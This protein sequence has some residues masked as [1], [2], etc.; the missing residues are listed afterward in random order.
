MRMNGTEAVAR[1][2]AADRPI[3]R[4]TFARSDSWI[5]PASLVAIASLGAVL[6]VMPD[7]LIPDASLGWV[8]AWYYVGFASNPR[9]DLR[10][11]SHLLYQAERLSWTLPGYLANLVA[12]PLVANYLTKSVFHVA[13]VCFLFG[14]L[15]LSSGLRTAAFVSCAAALY[16]FVLHALGANLVDGAA[17]TYFVIATYLVNRSMTG[18]R[19]PLL[20]AFLSG[21]AYFAAIIAHLALVV[22]L[23]FFAAYVAL[24]RAQ[25]RQRSDRSIVTLAAMFAAGGT[26][27]YLCLV[28]LYRY[29]GIQT[30]P[31]SLSFDFFATH[32]PN[33]LIWPDSMEWLP[34]ALWLWLPSAVM[35]SIA[36]AAAN[37]VLRDGPR[38]LA[39]IPAAQWLF[40]ALA[41]AWIAAAV[42]ARAPLMMLPFYV[43]YLIPVAFLAVG[44]LLDSHIERLSSR[45]YWCLISLT[46]LAPLVAYRISDSRFTATAAL[47]AAALS[48][49][50]VATGL[51][52]T[53]STRW[54]TPAILAL[55][56]VALAAIDY[57]TAD[58]DVQ[59]WNAYRHTSMADIY[60]EPR[61]T[62]RWNATRAE[63]YS[64]VVA[65]AARLA[66][67]LAGKYYQFWYDG[68]D[69]MGMYF[70]SIG[71]MFFAWSTDRI[72]NE[73]FPTLTATSI[74][75]VTLKPGEPLR[76]IVVLTRDAAVSVSGLPVAVR[77]RW[78]ER[79]VVAGTQY[80]A[81]YF[82]IIY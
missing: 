81:H 76:D 62:A 64:G 1:T 22:I 16:S 15:R 52:V 65:T 43:S 63:E 3:E 39:R 61:A 18:R 49:A 45:M 6:T 82:A 48:L 34:S 4:E 71:S 19:L 77:P 5:L 32:G 46:F 23:P 35:V 37:A 50:A 47:V 27:V 67:R 73:R 38:S 60:H 41:G 51:L 58:F 74:E 55:V 75:R 79:F 13:T 30:R 17:T 54:R 10:E 56:V 7:I 66:P 9:D 20:A 72:L 57:A 29:W 25:A 59:L 24:F 12:P 80:F 11:F 28:W 8:D 53:A 14:A 26:A 69:P 40:A 36:L 70:R 68:D 44:S 42:A 2:V 21:A 78:T 31:L 33:P